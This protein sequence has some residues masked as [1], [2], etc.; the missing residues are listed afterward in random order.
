MSL[1]EIGE[2]S[3]PEQEILSLRA[4]IAELEKRVEELNKHIDDICKAFPMP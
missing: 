2:L 3:L 1:D 4:Q